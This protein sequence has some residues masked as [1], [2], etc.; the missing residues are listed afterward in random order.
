MKMPFTQRKLSDSAAMVPGVTGV[1]LRFGYEDRQWLWEKYGTAYRAPRS[2]WV[3]WR[4]LEIAGDPWGS[5]G[6]ML[7][8]DGSTFKTSPC[9]NET[10]LWP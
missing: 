1:P 4:S 9:V 10:I 5:L 6:P 2:H 3:P 8:M 7:A